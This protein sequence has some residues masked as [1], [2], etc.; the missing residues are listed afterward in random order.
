MFS[1]AHLVKELPVAMFRRVMCKNRVQTDCPP[2]NVPRLSIQTCSTMLRPASI[3]VLVKWSWPWALAKANPTM[4]TLTS[5]FTKPAPCTTGYHHHHK[6][7]IWVIRT[8]VNHEL[9]W[10]GGWWKI[11][12][13]GFIIC[14]LIDLCS[15]DRFGFINSEQWLP[16]RDAISWW[17]STDCYGCP[18]ITH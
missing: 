1:I 7:Q 16:K 4:S 5:S 15:R 2:P 18:E 3:G 9:S 11:I 8:E 17:F 6:T 13:M 12:W 14:S 10:E